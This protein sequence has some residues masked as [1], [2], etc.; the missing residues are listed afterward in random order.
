MTL[1]YQKL[2]SPV[3][4]IYIATDGESLRVLAI[5]KNNWRRLKSSFN[6]A[7]EKAHPILSNTKQQLNEYFAH[8]RTHFDLPIHVD[9]TPFQVS[10]W[11]ALL[12]IPYGE[13]RNYSEQALMINNPNAVR[14]IGRS[15]GLNPIS[16]IVPCHR[17][18]GKSGKL[19]GYASGLKDKKYLIDLERKLA[20]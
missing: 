13:T 8:Q 20:L 9:G 5:D 12:A 7:K 4:A 19:T 3:G 14:A 1:L 10:A 17:V 16:I 18:I 6:Q 2:D 11:N 15:N